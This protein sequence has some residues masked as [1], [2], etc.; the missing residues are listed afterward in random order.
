MPRAAA[1]IDAAERILS[2]ENIA[3][4]LRSRIGVRLH[5]PPV[6]S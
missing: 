3:T 4:A 1:E 6:T 2:L 5:K